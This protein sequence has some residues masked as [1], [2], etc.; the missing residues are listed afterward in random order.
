MTS[1]GS[2]PSC[3]VFRFC[4]FL[5]AAAVLLPCGIWSI[6]RRD[7][8]IARAVLLIGFFFVPVPIAAVMPPDPKYFTP[9]DLLALPFGVLIS[10]VGAE[11]LLSSRGRIGQ[12]VAALLVL[13]IPIQFTSFARD[14]F[15]DYQNRSAYRFD[16]M[17]FRGVA[18]YVIARDDAAGVPAV[19]LSSDLEEDKA[20]QWMFHLLTRQRRDLWE[21]TRYFVLAHFKPSDIPS[22]S[23]LVLNAS[24]P[25]LEELLGPA[26]CS[27]VK[28]VDDF[29]GGPAAAI[30]RR[31]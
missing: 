21:R 6:L 12:T 15:T 27:L 26:R 5:L 11:S 7:F 17:N 31:N 3:L 18:A 16:S 24:N 2:V 1:L 20:T 9:R 13:A 29:A 25:R 28:I 8:S 14:Y 22:G 23:L 4:V 30:L 10:V 19:Y